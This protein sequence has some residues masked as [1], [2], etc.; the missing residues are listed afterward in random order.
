MRKVGIG[1]LLTFGV[2]LIVVGLTSYLYLKEEA[3]LNNKIASGDYRGVLDYTAELRVKPWFF[4]LAMIPNLKGDLLFKEAWSLYKI[5]DREQSV[6]KFREAADLAGNPYRDD[7]L[8]N[9]TTV[10]LS[11]ETV[12][13][14][15]VS[16]EEV[17]ASNPG[18]FSAQRNLEILKQIKDEEFGDSKNS[19]SDDKTKDGNRK[20]SRTRDKLEY[21][22]S[23]SKDGSPAVLRY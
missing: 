7:A 11:P 1:I 4:A 13:R 9:A 16:Y 20:R 8:F 17:L 3:K 12:E 10:D 15:I 19:D 18:H 22:D 21:R 5:G 14:A 6:K 2:L 23:D